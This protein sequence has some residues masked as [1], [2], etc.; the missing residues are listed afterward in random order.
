MSEKTLEDVREFWERHPVAGDPDDYAT[1]YDYFRAVDNLREASDGEPYALS[2]RIH[3]YASATGKRVLDYGCGHGYVLAH[4]A[5]NGATV[6]G[7][8]VTD[9]A[10]ELSRERFALLGLDGTFVRGDGATVPAESDSFDVVCSMGVLHHIPEP[11]RV[12]AELARVLR[13]G[14]Q[15]IVM[16]YN[17][18]SFRYHVTFRARRRFGPEPFRGRSLAEQV[19]MNDGIGNPLGRVYSREELRTLLAAFE[20]HEFLVSKLGRAELGLW[21]PWLERLASLVPAGAVD[22]LARRVGWNLYCRALKPV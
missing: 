17:R 21:R 8:D 16:V 20:G 5:R 9:R 10:V 22:A 12:V 18:R 14:G 2:D 4:Y 11:Q 3:G 13:P 15:L 7:V 6:V 19:N 1:R